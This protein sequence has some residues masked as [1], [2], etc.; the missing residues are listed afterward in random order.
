MPEQEFRIGAD[1]YL[2]EMVALYGAVKKVDEPL[3]SYRI[4]NQNNY[5]NKSFSDKLNAEITFY[6]ALFDTMDVYCKKL[7]LNNDLKVWRENSWFHKLPQAV[8]DIREHT[9]KGSEIILVDDNRWGL[10][11]E[12]EGR[13]I[14][15]FLEED[16]VYMGSPEND[17]KAIHELERMRE[18][19][20]EY[21]VFAWASFW[22][23]DE[24]RKLEEYLHFQYTCILNNERIIVF[25][26]QNERRKAGANQNFSEKSLNH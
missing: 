18:K 2:F 4:H 12:F 14:Y 1:T 10:T 15:P 13:K 16:G 26:L 25:S 11:N 22:W 5:H 6:D 24:Y 19:G 8:Q 7:K 20:A 3:G 17:E 21:I 23:L 9:E